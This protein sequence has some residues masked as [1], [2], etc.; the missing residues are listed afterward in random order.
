M[1]G[2][3]AATEH[4]ELG[5]LIMGKSRKELAEQLI[6]DTYQVDVSDMT[7]WDY[8]LVDRHGFFLAVTCVE[9]AQKIID[10][11]IQRD[12]QAELIRDHITS[13][14]SGDSGYLESKAVLM[15]TLSTEIDVCREVLRIAVQGLKP[16][17]EN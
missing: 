15:R 4:R 13:R 16:S 6:I 9:L 2:C 8:R 10:A 3:V 17:E 14:Y 12:A 5:Y 7:Q 1:P 11:G